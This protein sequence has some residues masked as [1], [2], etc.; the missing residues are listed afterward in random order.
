MNSRES[1]GEFELL[2]L[3]AIIG[4]GSEAYGTSIKDRIEQKAGRSVSA[5]ALYATLE[6]LENKKLVSSSLGESSPERGGRAKRYFEVT[7][8]GKMAAKKAV[9]GVKSLITGDLLGAGR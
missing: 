3:L 2:T 4:L 5:G 7:S 8:A 1:L 9:H 6:R